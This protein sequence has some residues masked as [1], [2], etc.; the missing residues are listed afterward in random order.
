MLRL[1]FAVACVFAGLTLSTPPASAQDDPIAARKAILRSFGAASR[2]PGQMLRGDAAFDLAKVQASL[3]VFAE[4][5]A[6]LPA[7]FPESSKTG[8]TKAAPAIWTEKDKFDAL[9]AKL[10]SDAAAA[11]GSIKDEA[12]FKA[13]M[14]EVLGTCSACHRSYRLR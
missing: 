1:A 3:K 2:D 10:A 13:T 6:K 11:A 4:G 5:A 8:D 14:P 9:A 7:L 12:S